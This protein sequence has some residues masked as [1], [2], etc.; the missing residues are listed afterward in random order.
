MGDRASDV[1][2]EVEGVSACDEDVEVG[3]LLPKTTNVALD[4]KRNNIMTITT[5]EVHFTAFI[6]MFRGM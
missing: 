1:R 2:R 5:I 4:L 6:A 3:M